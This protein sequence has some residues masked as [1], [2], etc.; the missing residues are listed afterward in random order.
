VSLDAIARAG[1]ERAADRRATAQ[2][3]FAELAP[4]RRQ[5]GLAFGLI[6]VGAA[7]QAGGPWL[8]S[9]AID[10]D[11]LGGDASA[12]ARRMALL[13]A[14]Y[15]VGALAQRGQIVQ[16]G[17]VGQH[18]L[19]S[20]RERLF[21]RFQ[22]LPIAFFDRQPLGDLM[23]RLI[24]DVDTLN[25]L[26]SQGLTQLLGS[27]FSLVGIL[28]AMLFLNTP[29][30][31]VCFT[32]I[33]V[34]L[35]LTSV[36]AG[37]ARRA[38]RA[39]RETTGGV[40]ADLQE[41]IVG[42][43]EAQ[44]FNRTAA[45]IANFRRRNAAN[46]DANVQAV[47]ITSAFAPSMDLLSTVSSAL[48]IGFGGYLV[49]Q[50]ALSLGLLAAFLIYV[51]QFFRPIQLL[52]QVYA[53]AQAALAGAERIFAI[54]DQPVEP[55]VTP[56]PARS[57]SST[58]QRAPAVEPGQQGSIELDH[59]SF[60]Y[61]PG[62]PVLTDVTFRVEP[63]QTVALVGPTGAGKTTIANLIPRF[64]DATAGLVRV[65]G[66]DVRTVPRAEL[67]AGIAMVLQEPFLFGGTI[68]DNIG[69]GRANASPA[70]IEAAARAVHAH[71][72]IADLPAG[73]D[74]PLGEGGGT[75]SQG[76]RQLLSFARAVLA[77]P[78]IL[79]LDEATSNVDTRT[80]ALIQQALTT[81]LAGRTSVV[82]A[83]R[84]STIRQADQILV[85]QNGRLVERGRHAELLEL[86]GLYADLHQRQFRDPT[87][88]P[89]PA[90]S[91]A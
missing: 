51:Q 89:S 12:L 47:A 91:R 64:Y 88:P 68:A 3:I 63:G 16:V 54:F 61:Q 52:A 36:L 50:D 2:R 90:Q 43:R 34:M 77:A 31:L 57:A 84:L 38:F 82:I 48:V 69:Y 79:I 45:N 55:D 46:R 59:V 11:I 60:A 62:R 86:G 56:A 1:P 37:R 30:A 72:F 9:R 67:R 71:D 35:L 70:E 14:V 23:S 74:T 44:A 66:R 5:I 29:L 17:S 73:Y 75:L 21:E 13:A 28:V 81:L 22:R 19:A 78:R 65:E 24:N 6:L 40:T 85:V 32:I 76:Q 87:T 7:A 26:F 53:Q 80:E 18:L 4:F 33:P 42:I 39:T 20:W 15:L 49:F 10:Q 83:H 25:Q 58:V 41:E 27:L 8:I